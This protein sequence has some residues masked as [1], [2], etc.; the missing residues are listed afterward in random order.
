MIVIEGRFDL[1][2]ISAVAL[3]QYMTYRDM[4]V[5]SLAAKADCN[6]STVGHLRS[7]KRKTCSPEV[8]MRIERALDAPPG[9]LFVAEVSRVAR[10][11][12]R[13]S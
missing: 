3:A 7:G 9:S 1:K 10:E 6:R 11:V 2:L 4:T 5:R 13:A 8:A 12:A